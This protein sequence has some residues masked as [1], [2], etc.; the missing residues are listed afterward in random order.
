MNKLWLRIKPRDGCWI[1]S[2]SVYCQPLSFW[3]LIPSLLIKTTLQ[4]K[5]WLKK[6]PV[7]SLCISDKESKREKKKK[8]REGIIIFTQ[9]ATVTQDCRRLMLNVSPAILIQ[10]LKF[11]VGWYQISARANG[12][13]V[14][15]RGEREREKKKRILLW[16]SEQ[17]MMKRGWHTVVLVGWVGWREGKG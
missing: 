6:A 13:S 10:S 14:A 7:F 17:K 2:H 11:S 4:E 1:P 8:F 3:I 5:L 12:L 16:K 9:V 15:Q